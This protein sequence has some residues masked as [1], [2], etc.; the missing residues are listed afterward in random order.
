VKLKSFCKAKDPVNSTKQQP[1]NLEKIFITLHLIEGYYLK[2]N[3][4][5]WEL[6]ET[7]SP[8]KQDA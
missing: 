5:P 7:E 1:T 8:T 6:P 3:L 2:Y 4:D